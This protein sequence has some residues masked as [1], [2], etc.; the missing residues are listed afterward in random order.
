MVKE[1][2]SPLEAFKPELSQRVRARFSSLDQIRDNS[3]F[4]AYR[5]FFWCVGI[6]PTKTRPASEAL[7]RRIVAG[8]ELPSINTLVDAYNLASVESSIAIAA[9][10]LDLLTSSDLF[11]RTARKDERFRGIGMDAAM[12]LRGIEV[13][14]EDLGSHELHRGVPVPRFGRQQSFRSD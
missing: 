5:D 12:E 13:V 9:F 3:I 10:D 6:D 4:R 2:D 1:K 11:M 7:T 14:I 8:K